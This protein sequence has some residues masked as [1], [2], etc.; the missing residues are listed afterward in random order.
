MAA[1]NTNTRLRRAMLTIPLEEDESLVSTFTDAPWV[2]RWVYQE[3]R[4]NETGYLHA[5]AY[6]EFS[7]AQYFSVVK[8]YFLEKGHNDVHIEPAIG[9][10]KQCYDYCTK[11]DTRVGGPFQGLNFSSHLKWFQMCDHEEMYYNIPP[12]QYTEDDH[13][14]DF[15]WECDCNCYL[16]YS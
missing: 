3:E 7:S 8:R 11:A 13:L 4:G 5:Q 2:R 14:Y 6:L 12:P 15:L 16:S 10:P 1:N 9:T